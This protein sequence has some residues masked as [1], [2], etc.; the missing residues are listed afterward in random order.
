MTA[1]ATAHVSTVVIICI[2]V[3]ATMAGKATAATLAAIRAGVV[4]LAPTRARRAAV[5]CASMLNALRPAEMATSE[6]APRTLAARVGSGRHRLRRSNAQPKR[7]KV[8]RQDMRTP[9][10]ILSTTAKCAK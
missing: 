1:A 8:L 7:A 9:A 3:N 2:R 10:P 5:A 4:N 6:K